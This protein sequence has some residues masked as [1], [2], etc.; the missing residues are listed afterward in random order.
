MTN[1][2][3]S[4]SIHAFVHEVRAALAAAAVPEDAEPMRAYMKSAMPFFGVK[5][6]ARVAATKP[7]LAALRTADVDD[8]VAH[9]TALF[10]AAERR[11]ERYVAQDLLRSHRKK[12]RA[13]HLDA[14]E[15]LVVAGAW[16]DHVD[17]IAA[18]LVGAVL[19]VEPEPTSARL[20]AWSTSDDLWLRRTAILAQLAFG[21]AVDVPLLEACLAPSLQRP[22]FW[23][24]KA[25][26][27]ALRQVSRAD[28]GWV[29]TYVASHPELSPLSKKE[30]LRLLR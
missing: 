8:V 20:R 29:R 14:L 16:W 26:G 11:E 23:L 5:K 7:I 13:R 18:H 4:R 17:E 3:T 12:L 24:R 27:W 9:A 22:E 25:I 15:A 2:E 30:A 28:P 1:V 10:H 6:P 19:R 21:A